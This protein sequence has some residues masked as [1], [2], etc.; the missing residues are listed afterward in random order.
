MCQNNLKLRGLGEKA[1]ELKKER[2]ED[3]A[4][5]EFPKKNTLPL[6]YTGHGIG[7]TEDSQLLCRHVDQICRRM[8]PLDEGP[9]MEAMGD[10]KSEQGQ[11]RETPDG[12]PSLHLTATENPN[13]N[14]VTDIV[15]TLH[16]DLQSI[17][18]HFA[19]HEVQC[20]IRLLRHYHTS[21]NIKELS[22]QMAA[23]QKKMTEDIE[24]VKKDTTQIAQEIETLDKRRKLKIVTSKLN[25][26]KIRF[27][28]TQSS[29]IQVYKNGLQYN[30][31]DG[32]TGK[33][34]LNALGLQLSKSE[35]A[36]LLG[37]EH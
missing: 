5:W 25:D 28:W 17:K 23:F 16:G 24:A 9:Q 2:K 37:M 8:L 34:L 20:T 10:H 26:A 22:E 33:A 1:G 15:N 11:A 35:E 19:R 3:R 18:D 13:Y 7:T 36:E 27:K 4:S 12:D 29:D 21:E 6:R 32:I 14:C 31:M 30:A